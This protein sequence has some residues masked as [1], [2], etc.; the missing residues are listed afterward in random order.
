MK[1]GFVFLIVTMLALTQVAPL[2]STLASF[3]PDAARGINDRHQPADSGPGTL[4]QALLDAQDGDTITFDPTVFPPT[5]P[6]TISITSPLPHIY[7]NN[8]L[9]DASNAGV[10]L[11]GSQLPGDWEAGL[12]I[13]S[14]QGNTIRG[15]QISNFSGPGI[16][17]SGEASHNVIGGDRSIGTRAFWSGQPVQSQRH[18]RRPVDEWNYC[19]HHHGQSDGHGC[20]GCGWL[21]Q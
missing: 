1:N 2:T 15:L 11:D 16:A 21:G 19:Q 17:I 13:V 14:S 12:Q 18:W 8:L 9:L 7:A 3:A 4:R 6:V 10:I 5:A 20:R